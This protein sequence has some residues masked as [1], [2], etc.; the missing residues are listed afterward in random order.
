METETVRVGKV[1]HIHW[2]SSG[3]SRDEKVEIIVEGSLSCGTPDCPDHRRVIVFF[4]QGTNLGEVK[5]IIRSLGGRSAESHLGDYVGNARLVSAE[6]ACSHKFYHAALLEDLY[7]RHPD[8][9]AVRIL[10]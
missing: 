1:G 10:N 2:V 3:E 7:R 5:K 4:K 6:L 9:V 8:V